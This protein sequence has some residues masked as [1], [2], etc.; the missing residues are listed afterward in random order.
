MQHSPPQERSDVA[1]GQKG[2]R[3]DG[4]WLGAVH[5]VTRAIP[6]TGLRRRVVP[7]ALAVILLLAIA[8]AGAAFATGTYG[9]MWGCAGAVLAVTLF[10]AATHIW[11][12]STRY[13]PHL[14]APADRTGH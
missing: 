7:W 14:D 13:K 6:R 12:A 9:V 2:A 11:R 3:T 8:A 10:A 1:A 4:F 5:S